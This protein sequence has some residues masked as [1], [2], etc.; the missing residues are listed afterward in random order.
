MTVAQILNLIQIAIKLL[1]LEAVKRAQIVEV[2]LARAKAHPRKVTILKRIKRIKR[3]RNPKRT[4][5][6]K[7]KRRK[8]K[9]LSLSQKN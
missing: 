9:S 5:R 6:R 2:D 4:K 8:T 1:V 3:K 7:T